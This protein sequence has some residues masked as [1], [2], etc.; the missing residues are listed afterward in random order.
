MKSKSNTPETDAFCYP[1][2]GTKL[3]DLQEVKD[4]A[5]KLERERD[6]ARKSIDKES[7]STCVWKCDGDSWFH[8]WCCKTVKMTFD[9]R[10]DCDFNVCPFCAR[11]VEFK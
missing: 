11:K 2:A 6:A 5:R 8:T 10:S 7:P 9:G 1:P 3:P 4:F